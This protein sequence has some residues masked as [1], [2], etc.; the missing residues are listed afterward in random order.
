MTLTSLIV[1]NLHVPLLIIGVVTLNW[2]FTRSEAA[3]F[4]LMI[5]TSAMLYVATV[6]AVLLNYGVES[7]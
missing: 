3:D 2:I 4:I 5:I 6:W 1:N 7:L